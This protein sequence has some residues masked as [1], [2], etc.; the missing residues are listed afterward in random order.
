MYNEC[1]TVRSLDCVVRPIN[2]MESF[3]DNSCLELFWNVK[4]RKNKI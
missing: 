4:I 3:V 1:T 2:L